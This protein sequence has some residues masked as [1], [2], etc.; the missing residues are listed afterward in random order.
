MKLNTDGRVLLR[1][2]LE[3]TAEAPGKPGQVDW[4]H[5]IAVDSKGNLYLGDIQG[6]RAQKFTL[7]QP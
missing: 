6:K 5:A 1:V 3:Q 7:R 4:V 2:P